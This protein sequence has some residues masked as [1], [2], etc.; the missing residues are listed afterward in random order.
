[1]SE[2]EAVWRRWH[3]EG[4]C[5]LELTA[6]ELQFTALELQLHLHLQWVLLHRVETMLD[7]LSNQVLI[8]G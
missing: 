2:L 8:V 1:M 4:T 3:G 5:G 7:I 6:L